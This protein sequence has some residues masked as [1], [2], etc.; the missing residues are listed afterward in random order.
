MSVMLMQTRFVEEIDEVGISVYLED[1]PTEN[2]LTMRITIGDTTQFVSR[3][4]NEPTKSTIATFK[5][6]EIG[7]SYDVTFVVSYNNGTLSKSVPM[8]AQKY[9]SYR[10]SFFRKFS[11]GG[12][13]SRVSRMNGGDKVGDS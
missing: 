8:Y 6:L 5:G 12:F 11:G 7:V 2:N 4:L 3:N 13:T 9:D 10:P 1:L